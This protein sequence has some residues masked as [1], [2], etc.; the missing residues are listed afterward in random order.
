MISTAE[1][2]T[3]T[4][5]QDRHNTTTHPLFSIIM[6]VWNRAEIVTASIQSVLDQRLQDYE[7]L[8]IDDGSEDALETVVRPY[9]SEKIIYHHIPHGGVSAARN[10]GLNLARG[11]WIAYL[12]SDNSWHSEFLSIMHTKLSRDWRKRKA[13]YCKYNLCQKNLKNGQHTIH[14]I[15]GRG[16]NFKK[17][18][19]KNYIDLNT[20]VHSRECLKDVTR[21]DEDLKRLNDW[22]F[23]LQLTQKYKPLYVRQ[24]LMDYYLGI[25]DNT[26]TLNEP[27]RLPQRHIQRR[28]ENQDQTSK[29]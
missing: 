24:V 16:F 14:S 10:A 19:L 18:L 17:L 1:K 20:F 22:D 6:P 4:T 23:I 2:N 28:Y 12:D 25:T 13:A 7:L 26:I 21:F 15:E 27:L 5:H 8:I 11:K 9:L 29:Q 3:T